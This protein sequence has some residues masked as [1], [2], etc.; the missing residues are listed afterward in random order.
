[1]FGP[2]QIDRPQSPLLSLVLGWMAGQYPSYRSERKGIWHNGQPD[3]NGK[4]SCKSLVPL[5]STSP[6]SER[7]GPSWV[8]ETVFS[9]YREE[10]WVTSPMADIRP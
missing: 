7:L 2:P 4:I 1:M 3:R 9:S 8:F 5:A 6:P 10:L